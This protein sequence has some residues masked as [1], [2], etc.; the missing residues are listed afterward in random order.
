MV[1]KWFFCN[2]NGTNGNILVFSKALRN[3]Q[4]K[5]NC[6]DEDSCGDELAEGS[7]IVP[8]NNHGGKHLKKYTSTFDFKSMI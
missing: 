5:S 2:I 8:E 4:R 6:D 1:K 7:G 3:T